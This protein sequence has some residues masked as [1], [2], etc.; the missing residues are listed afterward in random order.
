[1]LGLPQP[2][3]WTGLSSWA[4]QERFL[5]ERW[6]V[7]SVGR[8]SGNTMSQEQCVI[9]HR[10]SLIHVVTGCEVLP[11]ESKPPNGAAQATC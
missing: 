9:W 8:C 11:C 10:I 4:C 5:S 6:G 2:T 7:I 3:L 1:M